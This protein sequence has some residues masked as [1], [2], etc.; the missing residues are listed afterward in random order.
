MK[1]GKLQKKRDPRTFQLRK[2]LSAQIELPKTYFPA[3][4]YE[5]V[6]WQ[7]LGNDELGNCVEAGQGHAL[8]SW[9][10]TKSIHL[11]ITTEKVVSMYS[12]ITGYNGNPNTDNG[13]YML[14]ALNY[15]R[16]NKLDGREILAYAEIK[17]GNIS[18]LQNAVYVFNG[19]LI[20]LEL[21][22][23]VQNKDVWEVPAGY[24][25][26]WGGHCV[27]VFAYDENYI[28]FISWGQVMKMSYAFY[29]TYCDEAYAMLAHTYLL[30]HETINNQIRLSEL[31]QELKNLSA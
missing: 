23:S 15:W 24:S 29:E 8:L 28:W 10:N 2:Y 5:N 3:Y 13:T 7:M 11:N 6:D 4:D 31:Y 18:D 26:D 21:P 16:H 30:H 1:L 22:E 14:D 9:G 12:A 25:P 17:A 19:A 20:G 27:F